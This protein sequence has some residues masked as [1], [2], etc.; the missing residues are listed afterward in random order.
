MKKRYLKKYIAFLLA[1]GFVFGVILSPK[2]A[3]AAGQC[4]RTDQNAPMSTN[5]TETQCNAMKESGASV[6]WREGQ[7]VQPNP[8]AQ[9]QVAQ[10]NNYDDND[11][12]WMRNLVKPGLS[13]IVETILQIVSFITGLG[14]ILLNGAIYHTVVKVSENYEKITSIDVAWKT[15]RDIGNMGFIF[16]LLYAA[17]NTILG[18][19]KDNKALIVKVIVVAVLINFSLFFTKVVIDI[20]NVLALVFYDAIAPGAAERGLESW[21]LSDAFMQH[22]KLTSLYAAGAKISVENI[23]TIGIM[24]SI[25]LLIAAFVLFAV[26]LMFIIRYVVLI[27]VLI[28]S[29]IALLS[30]VL[31]EMDKYRKQWLDALFGQA[32]FAPIYLALTWITLIILGGITKSSVFGQAGTLADVQNLSVAGG[33]GLVGGSGFLTTF[34][35]F[36]VV[37]A[38]LIISLVIAKEWANKAPG[39]VS[40]LTSF[41]TGAVGGGVFGHIVGGAGRATLGRLGAMKADNA[42]LQKAAKEKTGLAGAA[43]RLQL[44]AAKKARSGTFDVRNATL[45]TRAVGDLVSGTIG[46]TEIGKKLGLENVNIPSIAVGSFAAGQTGVGAGVTGGRKERE[47]AKAKRIAV[48]KK[49]VEDEYRKLEAKAIID[50]V[51]DKEGN[52]RATATNAQITE[53]QK[54]IKDMTSKEIVALN[55]LVLTNKNVAE[56]LT[57]DHLKAIEESKDSDRTEDEKRKIFEVHF[58]EVQGAADRIAAGT[59]TRADE[60]TLKN[61]S[62]K[63]IN[64]VPTSIFDPTKLDP[65]TAPGPDG[66]RSRAFIKTLTQSQIDYLTKGDKLLASEKQAVKDTRSRALENAFAT[67]NWIGTPDSAV[68]LMR[69]MRPEALVQLDPTKLENP[70]ILEAYS[71]PLLNK[72]AARSEFTEAVALRIRNAILAAG[73][74]AAPDS[75]IEKSYNWLLGDGLNIF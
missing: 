1:L 59:G 71:P 61:I 43:A 32:F 60:N 56:A 6:E 50:A 15:I 3:L 75:N 25:M 20:S 34:I 40:K 23:L 4:W 67:N 45:P 26:A 65:A 70:N 39:G 7:V 2:K 21:G 10:T 73:P 17:I 29:P 42:E 38:F 46:R 48:E 31:P 74:T 14:G 22:L 30:F 37:I 58:A 8:E 19:G 52:T 44:Y 5:I 27:I 36:C 66:E 12:F 62:E 49:V 63:E 57:A 54:T 72:M 41:A 51:V 33:Q 11:G 47:E 53:M 16:V 69:K 24:G 28:L 13:W 9:A 55:H 68:E 35:N 18:T 64:Y